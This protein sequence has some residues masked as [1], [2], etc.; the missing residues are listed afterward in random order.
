M[1]SVNAAVKQ[2]LYATGHTPQRED[3][4]HD[5]AK[6][7]SEGDQRTA[8]V[9]ALHHYLTVAEDETAKAR[10]ARNRE[11]V[12]AYDDGVPVSQLADIMG[13]S[14]KGVYKMMDSVRS[15]T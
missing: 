11:V 6:M 7:W 5:A 9:A 4:W 12:A 13:A 14:P 1:E 2:A 10:A 3:E 8:L 15:E